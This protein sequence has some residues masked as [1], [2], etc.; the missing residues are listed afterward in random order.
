MASTTFTPLVAEPGALRHRSHAA[1]AWRRFRRHH[2]ALLGLVILLVFALAA[3]CAPL[4]THYGVD[5][6]DLFSTLQPPSAEHVLGTDD[7]GRDVLTRLLYGGRISLTVG[8]VAALLSTVIGLAVGAIAGYYGGLVDA[9]LMRLVDLLLAFPTI[10]LLLILF[11]IVR[12]SVFTDRLAWRIRLA[13]PGAD[14]AWRVA[15]ATPKRVRR[16]SPRA[17]PEQRAH[18]RASPAAKHPRGSDSHHNA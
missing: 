15:R 14:C 18:H 1:I 5:E 13:V 6:Q 9:A 2:M 10:F 17:R 12:A 4:I 3:A 16:S 7:L 11:S 8:I